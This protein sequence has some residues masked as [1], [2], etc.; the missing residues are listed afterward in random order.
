MPSDKGMGGADESFNT[1]F[2]QTGTG[3]HVPR[4]IMVDL[5]PTVVGR[6]PMVSPSLCCVLVCRRNSHW[7]LSIIVP[8][9]AADHRKGKKYLIQSKQYN[10]GY[11][12]RMPQI[13]M[14]VGTTPLE[15]R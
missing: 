3:R 10:I 5:E 6:V 7:N 15:R 13:T 9:G 2:S 1:F 11:H 12:R 4:S 8:S 14:H